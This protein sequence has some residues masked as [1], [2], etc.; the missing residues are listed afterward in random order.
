MILFLTLIK[1]FSDWVD[2]RNHNK[3][4]KTGFQSHVVRWPSHHFLNDTQ[5]SLTV[6]S[7]LTYPVTDC[8]SLQSYK[9]LQSSSFIKLF[10]FLRTVSKLV[11]NVLFSFLLS[12][13]FSSTFLPEKLILILQG[14][15]QMSNSL[16]NLPGHPPVKLIIPSTVKLTVLVKQKSVS[17]W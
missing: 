10:T 4:S 6:Q 14:P 1:L 13:P 11:H 7:R 2:K 16:G 9:T 8:L 17:S 12:R 5:G 15:Y 3:E